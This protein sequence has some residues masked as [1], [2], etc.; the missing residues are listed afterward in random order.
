MK[1]TKELQTSMFQF[2]I[3]Y[4]LKL[5]D[6]VTS[7][8]K[9]NCGLQDRLDLILQNPNTFRRSCTQGC[10]IQ[11]PEVSLL[12]NNSKERR[13][14]FYMGTQMSFWGYDS[15][16][17]GCLY[18]KLLTHTNCL[19][20]QTHRPAFSAWVPVWLLLQSNCSSDQRRTSLVVDC[21][22][23][24]DPLVMAALPVSQT[25]LQPQRWKH[26]P[27]CGTWKVH[28]HQTFLS[29]SVQT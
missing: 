11:L 17:Y 6:W 5:F 21:L 10:K 2:P 9:P 26:Q 23:T 16:P 1:S 8:V 20:P 19:M 12:L 25:L 22:Q 3:S 7:R 18:I 4:V 14:E 28:L 29:N 24:P 27:G 13:E 15:F